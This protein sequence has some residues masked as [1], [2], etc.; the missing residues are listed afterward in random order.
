MTEPTAPA[1]APWIVLYQDDA[2]TT[3]ATTTHADQEAAMEAALEDAEAAV[4]AAVLL[5]PDGEEAGGLAFVVEDD[6]D[7][8]RWVIVPPVGR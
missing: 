1:P 8:G 4:G 6:P 3:I 2:G 7:A 5:A